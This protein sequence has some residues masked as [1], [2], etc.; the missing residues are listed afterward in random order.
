VEQTLKDA[1]L[2]KRFKQLDMLPEDEKICTQGTERL[3][4]G[5]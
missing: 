3:N 4:P 5:F 1:E 2:I